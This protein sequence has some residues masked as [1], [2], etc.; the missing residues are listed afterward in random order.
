MWRIL[1]TCTGEDQQ[2]KGGTSM[3]EEHMELKTT[4]F[5]PISNFES[6]IRTSTQLAILEGAGTWRTTTTIINNVKVFINNCLD[7]NV[8]HSVILYIVKILQHTHYL[9]NNL[10]ENKMVIGG[11]KQE[12]LDQSFVLLG[13]RQQGVP[14]ILRGLMLP[15]GF[16]PVYL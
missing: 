7:K 8:L 12:T 3:T 10:V 13:T 2:I 4:V 15:D 5:K 14:I 1:C 11:S 16:D 6:S 9:M